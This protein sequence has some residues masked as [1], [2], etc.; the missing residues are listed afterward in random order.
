MRLEGQ[1]SRWY[2]HDGLHAVLAL[3]AG[4]DT[5]EGVDYGDGVGEGFAGTGLRTYL[6]KESGIKIQ[7]DGRQTDRRKPIYDFTYEHIF[8]RHHLR[9]RLFLHFR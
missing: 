4:D 9:N 6:I 8:P 1:F 2:N 5:L 3:K 7:T